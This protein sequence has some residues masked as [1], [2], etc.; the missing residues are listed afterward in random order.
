[1]LLPFS[2]IFIS[3]LVKLQ[4]FR[5]ITSA[6]FQLPKMLLKVL[7]LV[8]NDNNGTDIHFSDISYSSYIN[9]CDMC[10][11]LDFWN[12]QHAHD[13]LSSVHYCYVDLLL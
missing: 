6:L 1:M 5:L 2:F 9:D 3:V 13:D 4:V 8:N 11:I 12:R 10:V 7:V